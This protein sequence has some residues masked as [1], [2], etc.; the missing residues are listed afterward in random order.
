MM[1]IKSMLLSANVL[2]PGNHGICHQLRFQGTTTASKT[3]KPPV[4]SPTVKR[5]KR[6]DILLQGLNTSAERTAQN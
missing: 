2:E 3:P 4:S 1:N 6:G 5:V